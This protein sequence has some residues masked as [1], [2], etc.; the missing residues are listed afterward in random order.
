MAV[1]PFGTPQKKCQRIMEGSF[2]LIPVYMLVC[3]WYAV[4][5]SL[6]SVTMALLGT[7]EEEDH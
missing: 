7:L 1:L 3:Y 4:W 5:W 6:K 2:C